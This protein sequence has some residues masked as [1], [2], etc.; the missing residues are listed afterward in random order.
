M[1]MHDDEMKNCCQ[2]ERMLV[3]YLVENSILAEIP[4]ADRA[5]APALVYA[6]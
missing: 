1:K 2:R 4:R 3:V 6:R 5:A